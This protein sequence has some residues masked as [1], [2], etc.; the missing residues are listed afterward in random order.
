M[1]KQDSTPK[2][3]DSIGRRLNFAMSAVDS[4]TTELLK[5]HDL[6]RVQWVALSALWQQDGVTMTALADYLRA[7][8]S[9]TSRLLGRM[10]ERG[11]IERRTVKEDRRIIQIWLTKK[12]KALEQ[13]KDL[14]KTVNARVLR[15][16]STGERKLLAKALDRVASNAMREV[17]RATGEGRHHG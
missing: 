14:H 3:L 13:L 2:H 7:T 9:S 4:L 17:E 5:E 16:L 11:L 6:S 8:A 15:G 12:G 1:T 10:E